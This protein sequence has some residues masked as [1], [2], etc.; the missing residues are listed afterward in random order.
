MQI[1]GCIFEGDVDVDVDG[2]N[3]IIENQGSR[4]HIR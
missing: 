1:S 2:V 4:F 3:A